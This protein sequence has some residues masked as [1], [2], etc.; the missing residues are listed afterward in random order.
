MRYT[1][2]F[3]IVVLF[4]LF[5]SSVRAQTITSPKVFLNCSARCYGEYVRSEI[6]FFDFVRDRYA[7]DIEIFVQALPNGAGGFEYTLTFTG[8]NDYA[9]ST[10]TRTFSTRQAD[11]R[12]MIRKRMVRN[13]KMGLVK[14]IV[15]TDLFEDVLV[16]FP[17]SPQTVEVLPKDKWDYW[18]FRL[19]GRGSFR[20]ESN[21]KNSSIRT[22]LSINRVTD[23]SKF[24]LYTYH[25]QYFDKYTIDG[26]EVTARNTNYG[27]SS[28][29]VKS[30]SEHWS[31]GGFYRGFHSVYSNIAFSHSV[32]PAIEYSMY[33]VSQVMRHQMRWVYQAGFR[34]RNYLETTIF[35]K[36]Q[37]TL[38]YHQLTGIMR[39]TEPWG[40]FSAELNGFQYLHDLS[41]NRLSLEVD[42]NWRVAQGLSV[43]LNSDF[44]LIN[45]QISLA[46]VEGDPSQILLNNRQ[47]PT[48]FRFGTSVGMSYT[49]GSLNNNVINPRFSNVN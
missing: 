29:F 21:K 42:L 48:N 32:A 36:L 9:G 43:W 15:D 44:S 45:N 31:A 12:D 24:S 27:V 47:L 40:T 35:D 7:A 30:L 3:L 10:T 34:K 38:P 14:F 2:S 17:K 11:T 18:V 16:D 5:K 25:N 23:A 6:S 49:F 33:P 26:E 8:K 37:E 19:G 22:D 20:S 41:K 28:L 39:I 13:V 46:K 1:Y 4:S